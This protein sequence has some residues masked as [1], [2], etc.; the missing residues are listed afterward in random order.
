MKSKANIK[1]HSL[2]QIL[3]AFPV[4]FFTG[5]LIFDAL[6]AINHN[7]GFWQTGSY[8]EIAGIIAGLIA[9]VPGLI[10]YLY[11]VPP[12]SSAKKR[13]TQHA[14]INVLMLAF[15]TWAYV[16]RK[17]HDEFSI[18][19]IN[20]E[21]VGVIMICV[22]GWMGGTLVNRNQIGVD[23]RYANAGKWK[24]ASPEISNGIVEAAATDELKTDQMKLLHVNDTRIVVAKTEKGYVAFEDRC[25]HKG[26]SLAGGAMICGTVQCPW[27]GSQFDVNNGSCKAG[28]AKTGIK[29]YAVTES[30]GKVYVAIN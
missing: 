4:A 10:D 24:E 3:I 27:H 19:V 21:I 12:D 29:T 7:P 22:A 30:D 16:F 17:N 9:A 1:G 6:G 18:T 14:I 8:L 28:P 13:G 11:T 26:G 23:I 20:L 15:F 2:H 25:P 5:T